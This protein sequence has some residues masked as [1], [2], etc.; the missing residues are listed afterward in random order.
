M[1]IFNSILTAAGDVLVNIFSL[2]GKA[3][4]G[5]ISIF[6]D[7]TANENAGELTT[8]GYAM[9]FVVGATLVATTIYVVYNLIRRAT[10]K[11]NSGARAIG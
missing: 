2:I 1:N 5:V 9:A 4:N 8:I 6:Y 3:F 11:V 7:A 10:N